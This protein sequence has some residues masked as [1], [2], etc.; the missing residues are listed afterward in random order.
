VQVSST[1]DVNVT[2]KTRGVREQ[3]KVS[4]EASSIT[5]QPLD[6]SGTV[7][8]R[9]CDDRDLYEIPLAHRSS[10]RI[11]PTWCRTERVEP[12]DPSKAR[13]TAVSTGGSSGLNNEVSVDGADNSDDYIADFANFSPESI[14]E[15][16]VRTPR[17]MPTRDGPR[18]FRCI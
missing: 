3:V 11:S 1:Y 16:C 17:K 18:R 2:L 8:A 4:A 13:I 12:S 15:F 6:V 5:T 14:E 7:Q 10:L 9:H